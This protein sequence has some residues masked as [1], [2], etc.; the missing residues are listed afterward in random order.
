IARVVAQHRA[1]YEL[2]DGAETFNAQPAPRFLKRGID[3]A[4]RPAVGDFVLI[5][6]GTPPQIDAVLPRRTLLSRAAAGERHQLQIIAANVD[7]V[8][9]LNGLDGDLNAAR[10]ERYLVLVEGSGAKEVVVLTKADRTEDA[11]ATMAALRARMPDVEI[12]AVNAKSH[13]SIAP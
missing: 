7:T 10:V 4:E 9:V 3:P 11:D 5:S 13:D 6:P 8:F 1:G 2:H 12:I